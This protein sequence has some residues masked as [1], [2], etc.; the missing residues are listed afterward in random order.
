MAA[1]GNDLAIV[2]P[3]IW[4]AIIILGVVALAMIATTRGEPLNAAWMVAAAL[5]TYAVAYRFY[6]RF[7]ASRVLRLDGDRATPAVRLDD[8]LDYVP[9][10]RFVLFGHHFAAIA[11][12]G[13]LVG[14]VL[15]AQM[16]Q[17][18]ADQ[19]AEQLQLDVAHHGVADPVDEGRLCHLRQGAG[20][21]VG[22]DGQRQDDQRRESEINGG[23]SGIAPKPGAG[24]TEPSGKRHGGIQALAGKENDEPKPDCDTLIGQ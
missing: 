1:W 12:A 3:A 17:V 10:N 23:Q 8:G 21:P 22:R 14:P 13:P 19:L 18:G 16:G 20:D 9:T 15:A 6:S 7:I 24:Q 5:A 11:G 2:K 4:A